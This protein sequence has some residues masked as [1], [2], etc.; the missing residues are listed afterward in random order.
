LDES[1]CMMD[2][3][4]LTEWSDSSLLNFS[5][6]ATISEARTTAMVINTIILPMT[7]PA[8]MA[9]LDWGSLRVD[10]SIGPGVF[11]GE[12]CGVVNVAASFK[13]CFNHSTRQHKLE[14]LLFF[15]VTVAIVG[16]WNDC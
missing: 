14:I 7:P 12:A 1:I 15:E 10:V 4:G 13:L 16:I 3:Q 9:A 11:S 2:S 8:I 6:F 5:S